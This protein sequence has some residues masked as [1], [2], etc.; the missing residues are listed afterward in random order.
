M[1]GLVKM[2]GGVLVLRRVAAANMPTGQTEAQMHPAISG[3]QTVLTSIGARRDVTYLVEVATLLCHMFLFSFLD[4]PGCPCLF[5]QGSQE[6]LRE[7]RAILSRSQPG[8]AW[9]DEKAAWLE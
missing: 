4:A 7:T 8:W 2:L 5:S 9:A 1:L 6:L 3:F